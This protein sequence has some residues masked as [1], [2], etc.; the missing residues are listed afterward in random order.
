[1]TC[2]RSFLSLG[3][4]IAA[5]GCDVETNFRPL[6]TGSE[7]GSIGEDTA[8]TDTLFDGSPA[9]DPAWENVNT[10]PTEDEPA[11][12]DDCDHSSD[13]IYV[14]SA[15]GALFLF[16]PTTLAL[17]RLGLPRCP[18]DGYPNSMAVSRDGTAYVRYSTNKVYAVD[19]ETLACE[20][21]AYSDRAT[22]FGTFGM[23]YA[24][25]SADGWQ[26]HL[27][28]ANDDTLASLNIESGTL[29]SLG[30]IDSLAELSG[31]GAGELWAFMP[32]ITPPEL[33]Q[34]DKTD[35]TVLDEIE[36]RRLPDASEVY[37]FAFAS[38]GGEFWLFIG[39]HDGVSAGVY[40]VTMEGEVTQEVADIGVSIIGAGVSTCAPT[41]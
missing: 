23:G 24:S 6:V 8:S 21:T 27:Y 9:L 37:N 33:Q 17:T 13:L 26:E 20:E 1:M 38:W 3:L 14:V 22:Q 31:N 30:E 41:E 4:L 34:L 19:V 18:R 12:E 2:P 5:S 35:A 16:D 15:E 11:P 7:A 10:E 36:L 28:V 29:D 32:L 39:T 25:D 40:R